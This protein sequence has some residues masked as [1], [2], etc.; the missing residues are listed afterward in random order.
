M[1]TMTKGEAVKFVSED[2]QIEQLKE[3]GWVVEGEDSVEDEAPK[4]RGRVAKVD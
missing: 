1:I 4:R 3:T 2:W